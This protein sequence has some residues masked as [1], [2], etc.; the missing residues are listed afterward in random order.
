MERPPKTTITPRAA[1]RP[2]DNLQMIKEAVARR[3][4]VSL[5]PARLMREEIRQRRLAPVRITGAEL[6]RPLGIIHRR[7][8][9]FNQVAQAFLDSLR[10]KPTSEVA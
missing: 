3:L 1:R 9:R 4:G 5:L 10:E 2:L 6:Y 7:R 8:K